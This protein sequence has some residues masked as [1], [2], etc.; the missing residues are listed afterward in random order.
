[1]KVSEELKNTLQ[2]YGYKPEELDKEGWKIF[3]ETFHVLMEHDPESVKFVVYHK[4]RQEI[5][6]IILLLKGELN[7]N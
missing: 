3:L 6:K 5:K 7:E 2:E 4:L 1:M